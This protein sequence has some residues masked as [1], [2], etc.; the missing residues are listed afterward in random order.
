[1]KF[2]CPNCSQKLTAKDNMAGWIRTCPRCK[3]KIAVPEPP[4]AETLSKDVRG[5]KPPNSL[6]PRD[7]EL[8]DP[9]PAA[10]QTNRIHGLARRQEET[11]AS[12]RPS[13]EHKG[14]R[15]VAWP[16]D[17]L[18]YPASLGG[19]VTLGI[20]VGATI[21]TP[22]VTWIPFMGLILW[23]VLFLYT[24]WYLAECVHDS[25]KGGIRAPDALTPGLGEMWSRVSYLLAVYVLFLAPPVLYYVFT[26]R[27]D[28]VFVGL[29]VWASVLFPIG[30]LAMVV[31]DA[32]MA[33]NPFLLLGAIIRTFF[34]YIGLLAVLAVTTL[35][36]SL[37][38][39]ILLGFLP[40]LLRAVLSR[41][42]YYYGAMILAHLLGR[43]YWRNAEKL[44]WGL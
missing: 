23:G 39:Y 31:L 34:S 2:R 41:A 3:R 22:F 15:I 19:L 8:F 7:N 36:I 38:L 20:I 10:R 9:A 18:L 28:Y 11:L 6:G 29:V 40:F 43:F 35:A 4:D 27:V 32:T 16:L 5:A 24:G 14:E 12:F 26:Q 17:I 30:L 21:L 1:M 13:P 25:A 42:A 33:L 44:D 37:A